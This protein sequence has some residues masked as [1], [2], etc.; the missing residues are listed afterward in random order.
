MDFLH[1]QGILSFIFGSTLLN[2]AK[3][4]PCLF[5][6]NTNKDYLVLKFKT[7]KIPT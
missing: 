6:L 7:L 4:I 1:Y 3:K 2:L 5:G